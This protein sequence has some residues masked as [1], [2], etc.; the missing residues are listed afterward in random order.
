MKLMK[1]K[2]SELLSSIPSDEQLAKWFPKT[3][4]IPYI[5]N[6]DLTMLALYLDGWTGKRIAEKLSLNVTPETVRT[7]IKK[8]YRLLRFQIE[9]DMDISRLFPQT[10]GQVRQKS[11]VRPK[12]PKPART[13]LEQ[14]KYERDQLALYICKH[15]AVD[16]QDC[17]YMICAAFCPYSRSHNRTDC[18]DCVVEHLATG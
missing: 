10:G 7:R 3:E 9:I 16:A 11:N 14:M 18:I 12:P 17:R 1:L 6:Q 13:E 4:G 8:T 5:T 2:L 15:V